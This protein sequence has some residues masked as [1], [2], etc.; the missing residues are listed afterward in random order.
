MVVL[1]AS[2]KAGTWGKNQPIDRHVLSTLKLHQK[3]EE[4]KREGD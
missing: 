3:K 2:D 4:K 1:V